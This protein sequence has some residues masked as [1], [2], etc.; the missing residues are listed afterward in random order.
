MAAGGLLPVIYGITSFLSL[1]A[2]E[3]IR[4]D[5]PGRRVKIV[6]YRIHDQGISHKSLAMTKEIINAAG[7]SY[8]QLPGSKFDEFMEKFLAD[9]AP[10]WLDI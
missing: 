10:Q 3:Q 1:R 4:L 7:V 5:L 9:Q 6:S 8:L 2:L